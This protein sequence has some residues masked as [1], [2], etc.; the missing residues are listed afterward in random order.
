MNDA[1]LRDLYERWQ[2]DRSSPEAMPLSY[3]QHAYPAAA[4]HLQEWG[5]TDLEEQFSP[6]EIEMMERVKRR[7]LAV[8]HHQ[9]EERNGG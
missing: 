4:M 3:W 6:E 5:Q 1:K 7:V 9:Q 8:L 2:I